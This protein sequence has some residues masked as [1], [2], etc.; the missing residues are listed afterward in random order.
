MIFADTYYF[1]AIGNSKDQ[2]HQTSIE[3]AKNY[4]GSLLTTEW[5]LTE[6]GDA[7]SGTSQRERFIALLEMLS[8]DSLWTVE[9]ATHEFFE[10]A[11]ELFANRI[12]KSWSLTDCAS[13]VLMQ[14]K[15]IKQALTADRHFQQAGFEALLA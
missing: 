11:V 5:V 13:F 7:L 12:D 2:G 10:K 6:V 1:L 14:E 3:F 15:G 4:S 8:R 9:H